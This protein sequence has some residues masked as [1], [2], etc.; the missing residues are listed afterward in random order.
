MAEKKNQQ[1]IGNDNK[2]RKVSGE[3]TKKSKWILHITICDK[4]SLAILGILEGTLSFGRDL[5]GRF[6]LCGS[7]NQSDLLNSVV[8]FFFRLL[9]TTS[10]SE[11]SVGYFNMAHRW[12]RLMIRC[13]WFRPI[14]FQSNHDGVDTAENQ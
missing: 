3:I 7:G 6:L 5:T 1:R 10:K 9:T 12:M 2:R 11:Q 4:E 8:F 14:Q 13:L